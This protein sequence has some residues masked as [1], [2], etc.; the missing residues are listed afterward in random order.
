[1]GGNIWYYDCYDIRKFGIDDVHTF[2][3]IGCNKGSVVMMA[4][5]LLPKT[6]I[7][8]IEPCKENFDA[9]EEVRAFWGRN[10]FES[11]NIA[12][13]DGTPMWIQK[14]R[15]GGRKLRMGGE[16]QFYTEKE[17]KAQEIPEEYAIES[18]TLTQMFDDFEIDTSKSY[19]VKVDCEG[20]ERFILQEGQRAL[21]II[22]G[23]LQTMMELHMGLGGTAADW[24]VF[25]MDVQKTH[26]MTLGGFDSRKKNPDGT[27][28]VNR[29]FLFNAMERIEQD[30]GKLHIILT[31]KEYNP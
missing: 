1:M 31:N 17:R 26:H 16:I 8:A 7:I 28:N 29:K 9:L 6:R 12:L 15:S 14:Y 25:L 19:V 23:S 21:E 24:N 3:D 13:G 2:L 22:Q 11:Y 18:K 10:I 5:I 20:G 30:R 27:R 4:K